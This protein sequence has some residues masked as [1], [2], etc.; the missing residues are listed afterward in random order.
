MGRNNKTFVSPSVFFKGLFFFYF[1]AIAN[2]LTSLL[3]SPEVCLIHG[4]M[5]WKFVFNH[6]L[7]KLNEFIAP[8]NFSRG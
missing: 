3:N 8:N 6:R 1:S 5:T 4:I 7:L 2:P